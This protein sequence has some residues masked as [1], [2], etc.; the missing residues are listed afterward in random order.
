[1]YRSLSKTRSHRTLTNV[2]HCG[3][4]SEKLNIDAHLHRTP[5][6]AAQGQACG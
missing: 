4:L 3:W 6:P 5:D 2:D 1:M